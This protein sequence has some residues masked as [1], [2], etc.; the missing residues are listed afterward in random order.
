MK[1][2]LMVLVLLV[3]ASVLWKTLSKPVPPTSDHT[4]QIMD[5]TYKGNQG[6]VLD[7]Q[8]NSRPAPL[9]RIYTGERLDIRYIGVDCPVVWTFAS[10]FRSEVK[11]IEST[12]CGPSGDVLP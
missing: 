5:V 8:I 7:T 6:W 1:K 9:I 3:I 2:V 11:T 12:S 10:L 4:P